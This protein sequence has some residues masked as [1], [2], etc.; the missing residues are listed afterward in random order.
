[1]T[2]PLANPATSPSPQRPQLVPRLSLIAAALVILV[3]W[4]AFPW[5]PE[6]LYPFTL[7]S[8]WVHETGHGLTAL[9]SG[10]VFDRL[11]I[12]PD[13]SGLA[14][15]AAPPGAAAAVSL[16]G[17]LAPPVAAAVMLWIARTP[18]RAQFV[19][20]SLS[21][22][23]ILSLVLWTRSLTGWI[24]MP[25]LA[26]AF[27]VVAWVGGR[28]ALISAQFVALML[29]LMTVT[30]MDYLF[31]G[32]AVVGGRRQT[33]DIGN[34]ADQLGG[35]YLVWGFLTAA[36]SVVLCL[37]GLWAAWRGDRRSPIRS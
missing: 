19:L 33:S 21:A 11:L 31:M 1:M 29:V 2:E 22:L 9:A 26:V 7:F 36:V 20:M 3:V 30:R 15:T 24:T 10:G 23:I 25:L 16:G 34:V 37:A 8:T 18:H 5:G 35:S 4:H 28:V 12:F 13:A 14:Y 17:L 6:V 32:S 27:V